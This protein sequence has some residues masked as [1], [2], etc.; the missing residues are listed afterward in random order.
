MASKILN[1][2]IEV[3]LDSQGA[4]RGVRQL[5]G[6]VKQLD[7]Q[8]GKASKQGL[9]TFQ[10]ALAGIGAYIGAMQIKKLASEFLAFTGE[11]VTAA[12]AQQRTFDLLANSLKIVGVSYRNV[13]G[14]L[15]EMFSR[16]QETTEYGDT[17]SANALQ[18]L[19]TITGDYDA[20]MKLLAP[21]LDFATAMQIDYETAARLVGQAT[22]GMTGTLSRYGIVLDEATK[23]Q[24]TSADTAERTNIIYQQLEQRFSGAATAALQNHAGW[25][26]Q[27][28]N[29]W[30]DFKEAVGDAVINATE[31]G[32]TMDNVREVLA[33]MVI[34]VQELAGD[35]G[36]GAIS[37]SLA[38]LTD[39]VVEFGSA[40]ERYKPA[41]QLLFKLGAFK[42]S[43]DLQKL[44]GILR[45]ASSGMGALQAAGVGPQG[46]VAALIAVSESAEQTRNATEGLMF[47]HSELNDAMEAGLDLLDEV[48]RKEKVA[49][50][51]AAEAARRK[52][53]EAKAW[54]ELQKN[55]EAALK[56]IDDGI[57]PTQA[58][59]D[60]TM[61]VWTT[62][63][64]VMYRVPERWAEM[65]DDIEE[66]AE[67]ADLDSPFRNLES[68][69][70]DMLG[71]GFMGELESFSDLWDAVWQDMAKSMVG[72]VGASFSDWL[73]GGLKNEKGEVVVTGFMDILN[74]R[75]KDPGAQLGAALGGAGMVFNANQQGGFAGFLQGAMGG[76]SFWAGMSPLL[77]LGAAGPV[78][79]IIAGVIG[80]LAG[81]FGG[82]EAE[83]PHVKLQYGD[84]FGGF[85][86]Y[87]SGGPISFGP[88]AREVWERSMNQLLK[89]TRG[90]YRTMLRLFEMPELFDLVE[91]LGAGNLGQFDMAP[92]ALARWIQDVW[93]PD[94]ME[95]MF[96]QAI[97]TGLEAYGMSGDAIAA[98]FD[99]LAGM[100]GAD[101]LDAL[102]EFVN[103]LV[104]IG[105]TIERADW[106]SVV[107]EVGKDK[108]TTFFEGLAEAGGAIDTLMTGWDQMSLTER[109]SD[110]AEIGRLFENVLQGTIRMLQEIDQLRQSINQGWGD[111]R[112]KL[113]LAQMSDQEKI[114]YFE[115]QIATLMEQLAGAGTLEEIDQI[116]AD[117]MGYVQSLMGLVDL[118]G[119]KSLGWGE[120]WG[121]WLDRIM[122]EAQALANQQLDVVQQDVQDAY[123]D[124]IDRLY[125]ASD[126]LTEFTGSFAPWDPGGGN[127]EDH[128]NP[129]IDIQVPMQVVVNNAPGMDFYATVETIVGDVVSSYLGGGPPAPVS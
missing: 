11:A 29:Y 128:W 23:K 112:E 89:D 27:L 93:L 116:N 18:R 110:V 32:R 75:L 2:A 21:T 17:D 97:R 87:G 37:D 34:E 20:A 96:G 119:G 64:G 33:R 36:L 95:T 105:D 49:A 66:E 6:G 88:D 114:S 83:G 56:T 55:A 26:K 80:G 7:Q 39:A 44:G 106:E 40:M 47:S 120:T 70:S 90:A 85:D 45:M 16:L 99:E 43:Q 69:F 48:E 8:A 84:M 107:A 3:D 58:L 115:S 111:M 77:G 5:E 76:A 59:L 61:Q 82:G 81:L 65:L 57:G 62:I 42:V 54:A 19:V 104:A 86:V 129:K 124:L 126:A 22:T 74:E 68:A 12:G 14:D 122:Q 121:E 4:V 79:L 71:K 31:S 9:S 51:A 127:G 118:E 101:R 10:K 46:M 72:I 28:G 94:A 15:N 123:E 102:N 25:V 63:D 1:L 103:V 38:D 41:F 53:E 24:L 125:E 100:P 50:E 109:A 108:L 113:Q 52:E 91:T 60:T 78:G 67:E 13:A 35:E 73:G 92:D 117:L 98:L 30:G